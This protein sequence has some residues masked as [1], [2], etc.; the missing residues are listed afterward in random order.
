MDDPDV[1]MMKF[2]RARK[3]NVKAGVAM[4]CAMM[5]WRMESVVPSL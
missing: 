5:K 4:L 2:L 1:L 3:Y